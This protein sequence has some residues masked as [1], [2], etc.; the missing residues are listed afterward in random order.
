LD[1]FPYLEHVET[2]CWKVNL[3]IYLEETQRLYMYNLPYAYAYALPDMRRITL[4]LMHILIQSQVYI[5]IQNFRRCWD[6]RWCW[7]SHATLP[8]LVT[9]CGARNTTNKPRWCATCDSHSSL[10]KTLLEKWAG[11]EY[12]H[13]LGMAIH[14]N[15][16][17]PYSQKKSENLKSNLKLTSITIDP[18]LL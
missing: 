15:K 5:L 6:F 13:S 10:L 12:Y 8:P 9:L 11:K 16:E 18:L 7:D 17:N 4:V 14:I 2:S 3:L 1:L